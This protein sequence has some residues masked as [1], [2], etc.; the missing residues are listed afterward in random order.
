MMT[1]SYLPDDICRLITRR[2]TDSLES[3]WAPWQAASEYGLPQHALT[4]QPFSGINVL[5][6]WQ[7]MLQRQLISNRWLTGDELRALGGWVVNGEKPTTI[8][9]YQPSMSLIR[10]INLEQCEGLPTELQPGCPLPPRPAPGFTAVQQLVTASGIPVVHRSGIMP[11]YRP[12]HD[13][14]EL[15]VQRDYVEDSQYWHDL[16]HQLVYATGHP[17]RLNRFGLTTRS[18]LDEAREQWVTALG[19]AFV[20]ALTG[21]RGNSVYPD[22]TV[23]W[24]HALG[25]DPWWLFQVANDARRAM[26][27]LQ[28]RRQQ[29]P[30]QVE[31]WQQI[32]TVLLSEHY[33]L[34]LNDTMLEYDEVVQRHIDEGITPLMAVSALARIYHWERHDQPEG[35]LFPE[36][37]GQA[38]EA[39]AL[40]ASQPSY[41]NYAR[42]PV[43]EPAD[44]GEPDRSSHSEWLLLPPVASDRGYADEDNDPPDDNVVALPLAATYRE[45]NPHKQAFIRLFNQ[46]APHENRWQ[47]FCDFVHMAA[48]SLYNALLQN[49]EF[50]ADYMQRVKRYSR[51]DAFRLSRLLSEVITGLEYAVGDFLGAIF[52]ALELGHDRAGQYFTPFPVSHMMARMQ[53]TEGLTK[54]GSGEHEYITV[55]DPACGA[56]GMII[57]MHQTLLEA[58]FNPQQQML[59]FCVDIDPVAAMMTYIQLSL[60]GVP[61][62][63][64][65]GNSLTHV[66]SQQMVT[67][68]Y[69]LGFW[70]FKRQRQEAEDEIVMRKAG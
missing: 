43:T 45:P 19:A 63:V 61:A 30:T 41:L 16:L 31:L 49:E 18:E 60:L 1:L 59:A 26:D 46:I 28:D 22:N 35:R 10:V 56:G 33:G 57:A 37:L 68:M 7:T 44:T 20:A 50:E 38:S 34:P 5:L 25:S 2:L 58:G 54:L 9:R 42:I 4:G 39:L 55:S 52:M 8:V 47:V 69:H 23:P 6:L 65:V 67:P 29:L 64:T 14:I 12:W 21:V 51:E 53:F 70:Q 48:C 17:S 36:E 11:V 3:G 24:E 66:M 13:R 62:V 32:A 15:P 40:F 27:Y